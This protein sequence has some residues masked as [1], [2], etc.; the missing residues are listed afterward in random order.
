MFEIQSSVRGQQAPCRI[1]LPAHRWHQLCPCHHRACTWGGARA[2]L[3]RPL[4]TPSVHT[5]GVCQCELGIPIRPASSAF[6]TPQPQAHCPKFWEATLGG[7]V[8]S[9]VTHFIR[10]PLKAVKTNFSICLIRIGL[11][12]ARDGVGISLY[13]YPK[14]PHQAL[15]SVSLH[16]TMPGD[17]D[18]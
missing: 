7:L 8:V 14:Y 6:S 10:P 13:K 15:C 12:L 4:D 18:Y 3:V 1:D 2:A 17:G 9:G 5:P 16:L 11:E